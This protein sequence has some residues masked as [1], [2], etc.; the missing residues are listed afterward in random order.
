MESI[1]LGHGPLGVYAPEREPS[2]NPVSR[3][4]AYSICSVKVLR[5]GNSSSNYRN[6]LIQQQVWTSLFNNPKLREENQSLATYRIE[7]YNLG[8]K[9]TLLQSVCHS[10]TLPTGCQQANR[11]SSSPFE[12]KLPLG[13]ATTTTYAR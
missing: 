11:L 6:R 13:F 7:T 2:R 9:H 3:G 1:D 5:F 10:P 8:M 12:T 4:E